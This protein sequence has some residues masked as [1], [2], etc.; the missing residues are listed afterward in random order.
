[1]QKNKKKNPLINKILLVLLSLVVLVLI[2]F[3][4]A[5]KI[6][7]SPVDKNNDTPI[8]F[9][10][11]KGSSKNAIATK[12]EK[13][14][15][16]KNALF[17][18]FYIKLNASKELY[19]GTY[20]LSKSMDVNE[21][22][23][24]LNSNKSKENEGVTI[25]F[26]EGKRITDYANKIAAAL[27]MDSEEVLKYLDSKEFVD[28]QIEKYWFITDTVYDEKI[29]HPL[30]GY[31]FP[32]T[33]EFKKNATIDDIA[34][35]LLSTMGQKLEVYKDEIEV[36]GYTAHE[37]I[38]LASIIEL[39]GASVSDRAGVAGV[40]YNRLNKGEPLGSDV[41]T[42]YGV[43]KD[44]SRDLSNNNLKACNGYNTRAESTCP[45]Y[46]LPIG[47]ICSP[48]LASISAAIE[49]EE[50]DYY[51]FVAD[52]NKKT[53]FSKTY[54]EHVKTVSNLKKEGLWYQY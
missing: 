3:V 44:F 35:K 13:E 49:P 19:A 28:K 47:P 21:I 22:I 7:L 31:F 12:L 32:D 4:V 36:S 52:K 8:E 2:A 38:T 46:G 27:S 51:F 20:T 29:Y 6:Y 41:T 26:I 37:L 48:S 30:E 40:F 25:T 42:Y 17:F 24:V 16:I 15:L 14:G 34:D 39:E 9:V 11:E 43:K 54:S 45:I 10:V 33:Y 23:E 50:N 53:Y 1:M 5:S 18:K